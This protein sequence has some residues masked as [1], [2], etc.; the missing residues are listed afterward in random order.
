MDQEEEY[1]EPMDYTQAHGKGA[2]YL[3]GYF[4]L[5]AI[6]VYPATKMHVGM[7]GIRPMARIRS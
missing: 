7:V 4:L 3:V 6:L 2:Y 1:Y 5:A